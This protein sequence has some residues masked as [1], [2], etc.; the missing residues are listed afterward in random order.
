MQRRIYPN[1]E[2]SRFFPQHI[3]HFTP[4]TVR[5]HIRHTLQE[6]NKNQFLI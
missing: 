1:C 5:S 6:A 2:R 4:D 3:G